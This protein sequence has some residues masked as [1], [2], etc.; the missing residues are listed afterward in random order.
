MSKYF[1]LV[2]NEDNKLIPNVEAM[3]YLK[4]VHIRMSYALENNSNTK[5]K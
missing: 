1:N 2:S 4:D 5:K 3:T